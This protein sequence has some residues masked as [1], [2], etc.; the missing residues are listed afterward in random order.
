MKQLFLIMSICM[1]GCNPTYH[2]NETMDFGKSLCIGHEGLIT[3]EFTIYPYVL[4]A[5]ANCKDGT[6]ITKSMEKH[7]NKEKK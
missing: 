5:T 7:N 3:V 2:T 6:T 4:Q 1:A